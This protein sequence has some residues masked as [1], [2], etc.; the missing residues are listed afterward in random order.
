MTVLDVYLEAVREPIGQL[1]SEPDGDMSFRY[2]TDAIPHAISASLPIREEPFGDV[3][4]RGFFSNLLFEN[5][6]RD[7]VMQRHGIAERDIVGLLAHIGADCPGAISCVPEGAP[8]GKRPGHLDIDYDV[9]DGAPVVPEA[10]SAND[11]DITPLPVEDTMIR[12]MASLRDNRRLPADIDDPS[13]LAGVQGKVALAILPNGRLGLPKPGSGAPT[14]HVLKVPRAGAIA[15]VACEHLATRLMARVQG[16]PVAQTRILGEGSLHG[17]LIT[18]FDRKV[19]EGQVHRVHQEDF[20]QALGFGH[21]LK[22]ER[23]GVGARAFTAEAIGML[24]KATRVPAV[25]RQAFFE[26]TLTNMVLGNSDNHAKNHALLYTAAR[27][28]LAP[29]YD[30]DPVLLDAGVTHEMSFRIGQARMADDV[31][32]DDLSALMAALGA[33]G[34]VKAQ[35]NRVAGIAQALVQG[36]AD[37]P[38]PVGKGLCDAIRQQAHH[39]SANLDID[40]DV[41]EFDA[42]PVNRPEEM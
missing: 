8:P 4:V 13:P 15:S 20:C 42:V 35:E 40:I 29:A 31:G 41:P 16:H 30:I 19:T 10:A 33:R 39:L 6:M 14:T 27:P 23:C 12:L 37:L 7:Q 34:F 21:T 3:V 17:L 9:L 11:F 26:I 5:E 22:Y 2:V 24:L 25:A 38:R 1:S 36:A 28:E 32:R 18:R